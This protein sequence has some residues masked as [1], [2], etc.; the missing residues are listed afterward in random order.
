[1]AAEATEVANSYADCAGW[2]DFM[3]AMENAAGRSSSAEQFKN[4]GNGAQTAALWLHAQAYA[5]TAKKPARYGAWLPIVAP[6]RAAAF[7]RAGALVEHSDIGFVRTE[8]ERCQALLEGQQHALD[9]IRRDAVQS[10]LD[11]STLEN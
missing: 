6:R 8:G 1:M 11:A 2:W 9:E 7:T 5:L 4:M 10:E 3:S